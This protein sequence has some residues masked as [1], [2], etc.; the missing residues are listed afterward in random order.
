MVQTTFRG[1]HVNEGGFARSVAVSGQYAYLADQTNGLIIYDILDPA[2][3]VRVGQTNNGGNAWSVA[4]AG[5]YAYL[6][7]SADGLR[8]YDVSD[9]A[10][11]INVGH[12][13]DGG[14][15]RE[16]AVSANS[17]YL[18]NYDDGLRIYDVSDPT[19]PVNVGHMNAGG[20]V[21]SVAVSQ[22]YAY[23]ASDT[24][25]L[26]IYADGGTG[27]GLLPV[28]QI[29]EGGRAS[30]VSVAGRYIYLANG[31]DGVRI[32]DSRYPF[33]V[34]SIAAVG[35]INQ[36]G[37]AVAL[38]V[39]AN[40]LYLANSEDG[41]RVYDVFNPTNPV[42]VAHVNEACCA[43]GVAVS[44]RAV[45]L[46][47]GSDGLRLLSQGGIQP[48]VR[49]ELTG[50]APNIISG[51]NSVEGRLMGVTISGGGPN[52]L[53]TRSD[54]SAIGGGF[55]NAVGLGQD[56]GDSGDF[57]FSTIAGGAWNEIRSHLMVD[58][59]TY[60]GATIGG[61][62]SNTIVGAH[63]TIGG[64]YENAVWAPDSFI[65]GGGQNLI[66]SP[67]KYAFEGEA[68]VIS[69]GRRNRI[70]Y[71]NSNS[72]ISGGAD[73]FLDGSDAN[74]A[75]GNSNQIVWAGW[76]YGNAIG[77]GR[78]NHIQAAESCTIAGGAHN[79]IEAFGFST[80]GGGQS[81]RVTGSYSVAPGGFNNIVEGDYSFA[82]G[83]HAQAK[84]DG[85]FV[86]ADSTDEDFPSTGTNQ[87]LIRASGGVGIGTTT[88]TS[89]LDVFDGSGP[90]GQGGS[91]H[92]GGTI[93]NGDPKLIYFGDMPYVAL[94]E[95]GADDQMELRAG[96][97]FFTAA[98]GANGSG[99][100]GI[101]TNAPISALH[102][103]GTITATTVDQTSDRAAKEHFA[104]ID[105]REVLEKV[106]NLPIESWNFKHDPSRHLGPMA[107]DFHTA[108]GLG[109][110]DK[111]IASVDA[112]GVALAAVQ[113]LN[114]KLEEALTRKEAEIAALQER[115]A[116][117]S[118]LVHKLAL[119]EQTRNEGTR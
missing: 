60:E 111:H 96:T 83:R 109:T 100:V 12:I 20:L 30:G 91:V 40:H 101:G 93:K 14:S 88:P 58:Y 4:V 63:S 78:R 64:G 21:L 48:I 85:S 17:V 7:N 33:S 53:L 57:T 95:N 3:P 34:S 73:N 15:A 81:N 24:N 107:Q 6:A 23:V 75:G 26:Q 16:V 25:G 37:V 90:D 9:P 19:H 69:G 55:F 47:N 77:G 89:M 41:L 80:V 51:G 56:T 119:T 29:N 36:G 72:T 11:P 49:L 35:H 2:M 82:A 113:G 1:G 110:D 44:S 5:P 31:E 114:Q 13:N 118:V 98:A 43:Y 59:L 70:N 18:A 52:T 79:F 105:A 102:V 67:N 45:C 38:A 28:T 99:R 54:F 61:G 39:Y 76:N 65:G 71:E 108:F 22:G 112:D 42:P 106:A 116:Q 103:V 86:W 87:F 117:L 74:I 97:F 104:R 94:G 32:Y 27:L 115:L 62:I 92:V 8:I 46:A 10:N 84:H 68:H 50:G 66:G